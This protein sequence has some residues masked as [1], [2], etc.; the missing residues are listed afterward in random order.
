MDKALADALQVANHYGLSDRE[1]AA[2]VEA[3]TVARREEADT[4][5]LLMWHPSSPDAR[6]PVTAEAFEVH[7]LSGWQLLPAEEEPADDAEDEASDKPA[8]ATKATAKKE[9]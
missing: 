5:G 1:L 8:K 2:V 9:T 3:A 7:K 4:P 6:V